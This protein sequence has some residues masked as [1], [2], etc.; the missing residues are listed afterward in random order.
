MEEAPSLFLLFIVSTFLLIHVIRLL[1]F[2]NSSKSSSSA[3]TYGPK[4]YPIIGSAL[5][6]YANI[7]RLPDYVTDLLRESPTLTVVI[8]RPFGSKP[9]VVTANPANIEHIL[10]TKFHAYPKGPDSYA[11]L[12]DLLGNGIFNVDGET[13]KVQRKVASH[14]FNTR[15]LRK[16]VDTVV[17][18]EISGRLLPHLSSAAAAK[19]TLDLQDV[20]QRFAFDNICKIAFGFDPGCLDTAVTYSEFT[21]AF[22]LALRVTSDRFRNPFPVVWRLKRAFGLG[23]EG[24]FR[25][26]VRQ[27]DEYA[28]H[29]IR[30]RR[31]QG[32][33]STENLDLLS[34]FMSSNDVG[35]DFLKDIVISFILAGMDTTSAALT[36]FFW[37]LS[38][39]R[40]MEEKILKETSDLREE[41]V[42]FDE[43]KEMV[44]LHASICEAMRLYPPVPADGKYAAEDDVLPDGTAVAK[45][46]RVFYH[47]YAMGRMEKLWGKDC[48]EFRPERWLQ[49]D[50][51]MEGRMK[52]VGEDPYKYPVFQA[53]PRLCLGKEMAFV[54]MKSI[55]TA[56]LRLFKIVPPP[57]F[58][59]EFYNTLTSKMKGGFPVKIEERKAGVFIQD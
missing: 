5:S 36:W 44:Y 10:K 51:E 17:N 28:R 52:F 37:L 45:G 4:S 50:D 48:E 3:P 20:L 19:T 55:A 30:E 21:S 13:W 8:H 39:D 25:H 23:N 56:V 53:G 41:A 31:R 40:R 26:A 11:I 42:G 35:E 59:P 2:T 46:S 1:L 38:K 49:R 15:S 22:N 57:D 58:Q 32:I 27:I 7:H 33:S 6:F 14:E 24:Q 43:V 9:S 12:Y 47:P 29:L 16:F 34:R 18:T 54:Q